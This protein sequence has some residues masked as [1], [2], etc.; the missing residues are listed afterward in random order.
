[1]KVVGFNLR[2]E[3][4]AHLQRLSAKLGWNR[5]QIVRELLARAVVQGPSVS[6]VYHRPCQQ[7]WKR[8]MSNR[9]PKQRWPRNSRSLSHQVVCSNGVTAHGDDH[10]EQ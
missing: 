6:V 1:M 3:D 2:H 7:N 8:P 9:V 4:E 5:S 10:D